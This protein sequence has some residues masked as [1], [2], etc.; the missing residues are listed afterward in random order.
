VGAN[1]LASPRDFQ[2]PQA[3]YENTDEPVERVQKFEGRLWAMRSHSPLDVVAWHGNYVPYKY[4]LRKFNVLGSVSFDHPDP[5]L[6]T[7]LTSPS[8]STGIANMDFVAFCPRWV[9]AEHSFRPPWFHRNVMSEF[10]GLIAGSYDAK[11]GGF[12]PGGASLHNSMSA[13]GP[14]AETWRKA[15]SEAQAPRKIDDGTAFMFETRNV[16]RPTRAAL[17]SASL[18]KDYDKVWSDFPKEFRPSS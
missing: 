7:V 16:L 18:Q 8:E 12:L 13:H 10:M 14:D 2:T 9:V 15:S 6:F 1:G 4:D 11:A 17:T 5:S 3:A